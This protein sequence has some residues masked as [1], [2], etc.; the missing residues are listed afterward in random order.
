MSS[1]LFLKID[2]FLLCKGFAKGKTYYT[3]WCI[4]EKWNEKC[5]L[6]FVVADND[7]IEF[8]LYS[9]TLK[10]VNDCIVSDE[11]IKW[12]YLEDLMELLGMKF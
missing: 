1:E 7:F 5:K 9:K 8:K 2:K 12:C 3:D 6:K 10:T 4:Y 11:I